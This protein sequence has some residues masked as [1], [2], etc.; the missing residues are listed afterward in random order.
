K[1]RSVAEDLLEPSPDLLSCRRVCVHEVSHAGPVCGEE[2]S[3]GDD[4]FAAEGVEVIECVLEGEIGPV[5]DEELV[6]GD[7]EED[8]E[9]DGEVVGGVILE[10]A[11]DDGA[12]EA[13]AAVGGFPGGEARGEGGGQDEGEIGGES[14]YGDDDDA[15]DQ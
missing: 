6:A 12:G 7:G 15:G 8:E 4:D 10:G 14:E 2:I 3:R 11:F 5:G 1:R 13:Q 9:G